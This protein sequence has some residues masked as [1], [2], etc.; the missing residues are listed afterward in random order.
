MSRRPHPYFGWLNR[1]EGV[2]CREP[3]QRKVREP[4]VKPSDVPGVLWDRFREEQ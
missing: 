4:L 3:G 2:S 1:R